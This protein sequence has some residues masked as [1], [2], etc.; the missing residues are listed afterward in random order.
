LKWQIAYASWTNQTAPRSDLNL[1]AALLI[2][3][4]LVVPKF[5]SAKSQQQDTSGYYSEF[6]DDYYDDYYDYED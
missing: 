2:T 5:T 3:A 1:I 4:A 6:E